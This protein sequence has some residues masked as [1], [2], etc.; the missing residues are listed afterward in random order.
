M[1]RDEFGPPEPLESFGSPESLGRPA[2]AP[3]GAPSVGAGETFINRAANSIPGGKAFTDSASAILMR[4]FGPKP[5]AELTPQAEAQLRGLGRTPEAPQTL[6]DIYRAMRDGRLERTAAGSQQNPWAARLGSATGIGLSLAAPF[7]V[8]GKLGEGAMLGKILPG[9]LTG[10]GYGGEMMLEHGSADLTKGEFGQA[11]RETGAG[12]LFGGA[13][14]G[15]IPALVQGGGWLAPR[16]APMLERVGINQGRRVLTNGAD[17]LSKN[18]PISDDAVLAAKDAGAF[19]FLGS[20]ARAL[21]K[22]NSATDRAGDQYGEIVRALEAEGVHG[23]DALQLAEQLTK[24]GETVFKNTADPDLQRIY[25][26]KADDILSAAGTSDELG[27]TQAEGIKRAL[28][29]KAK[30]GK[31]E[32]TPL[33]EERRNVASM[34]RQSVEDKIGQETAARPELEGL[35]SQ[36]VPAKQMLGSLL[37]A[38]AAATR[39]ASRGAQRGQFS[40]KDSIHAGAAIASGHGMLAAPVALGSNLL[41]RRGPS[42]V[43]AGVFRLADMLRGSQAANATPAARRLSLLLSDYLSPE[44]NPG[45]GYQLRSPFFGSA[46]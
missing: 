34:V 42:T 46:Q 27:L 29:R 3:Q 10:A 31:F 12:A 45:F 9:M 2:Q 39:G 40:L 14:G 35:A 5:G 33:N 44:P 1:P 37:E 26:S 36:F 20:N 43:A 17:S 28:Q 16:V 24:Q 38:E 15:F 18:L 23:P 41:G 21:N 30:Y 22:L 11:A 19:G 6:A 8:V 32:E 13:L 4:L 25:N 7:P